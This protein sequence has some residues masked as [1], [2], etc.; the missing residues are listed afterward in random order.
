MPY[1]TTDILCNGE[2]WLSK[3]D[4]QIIEDKPSAY[5]EQAFV[6]GRIELPIR[7][8]INLKS[9]FAIKAPDGSSE[10]ITLTDFDRNDNRV[11]LRFVVE[12]PLSIEFFLP[13]ERTGT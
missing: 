1:I 3:T 9:V 10:E 8:Q 13:L 7:F 2:V 5:D 11:V 6:S 12:K 4:I